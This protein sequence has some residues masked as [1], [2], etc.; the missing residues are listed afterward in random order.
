MDGVIN[1]FS[2]ST[3]LEMGVDICG[4]VA[5]CMNNAPPAPANYLLRVARAGRRV[6]FRDT[7]LTLCK[8]IAHGEGIFAHPEWPFVTQ[9]QVPVVSLHSDR[10][11]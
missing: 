10:I 7:V 11:V 8:A 1:V 3:T 6:E 5:V 4:L 2:F 9:T